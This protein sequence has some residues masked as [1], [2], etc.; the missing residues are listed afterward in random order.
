MLKAGTLKSFDNSMAQAIEKEFEQLWEE[1]YGSK[2]PEKTR[3]DRRLLF[4][5]VSQGVIKYLRQMA[6]SAFEVSVDVEQVQTGNRI[7]SR[8]PVDLSNNANVTQNSSTGN[9]GDSG[10]N[11]VKSKGTGTVKILMEELDS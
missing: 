9:F 7:K 2:L 5:S 8:G 1:R 10:Y 6:A 4:I 3:D 11:K